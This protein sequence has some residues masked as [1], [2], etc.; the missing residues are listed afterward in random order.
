MSPPTL[1]APLPIQIRYL[2]FGP[3]GGG[4]RPIA[5]PM[6]LL[7]LTGLVIIHRAESSRAGRPPETGLRTRRHHQSHVRLLRT[8]RNPMKPRI[9]CAL[10]PEGFET[11]IENYYAK[12]LLA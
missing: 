9:Q 6:G 11:W 3:G 7:R 12:M 10:S 5:Q 4:G 8:N 1:A 2:I